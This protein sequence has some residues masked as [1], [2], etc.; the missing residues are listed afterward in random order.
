M[1]R[2]RNF[3]YRPQPKIYLQRKKLLDSQKENHFLLH[4]SLLNY[5]NYL[6]YAKEID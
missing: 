3:F 4:K 2:T 1:N 6:N 5:L